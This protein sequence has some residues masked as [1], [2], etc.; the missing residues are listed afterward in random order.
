MD[1]TSYALDWSVAPF[2]M[3]SPLNPFL[4]VIIRNLTNMVISQV[5]GLSVVAGVGWFPMNNWMSRML[6]VV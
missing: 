6:K 4:W 5:E 2:P 1:A 3:D